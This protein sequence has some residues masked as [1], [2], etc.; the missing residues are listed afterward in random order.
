MNYAKRV[1]KGTV[2]VFVISLLSALLGYLI[3]LVLARGISQESY[4]VFYA[5]FSFFGLIALFRDYGADASLQVCP[6]YNKPTQEGL[7]RHKESN[8]ISILHT[9]H[10]LWDNL[11]SGDTFL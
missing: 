7:F 4:G 5:V 1:F 2:I 11:N 10:N 9:V 6:Y 8:C 3:R